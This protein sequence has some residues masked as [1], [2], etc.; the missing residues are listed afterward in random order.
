MDKWK[1]V[2]IERCTYG[3]EESTRKPNIAICQGVGCSSYHL[4]SNGIDFSRISEKYVPATTSVGKSQIL[5]R[6]YNIDEF[7]IILLEHIEE[8]CYRLRRQNKLAQT[9]QFSVGYS[10]EYEGSI[11]KRHTMN[12]ATNLTMDI[13]ITSV[14][15][16]YTNC[17]LV[18]RFDQLVF[19]YPI[20]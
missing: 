9:I 17:I 16:I 4:H 19:H 12:R 10:A 5:L 18:S 7:L 3:L 20:Y 2:Y 14:N 6:N 11:R 1:A 13:Y 8:V 15:T